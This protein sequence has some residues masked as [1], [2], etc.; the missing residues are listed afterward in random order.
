MCHL[1]TNLVIY[2]PEV[3][4]TSTSIDT[5]ASTAFANS[6]EGSDAAASTATTYSISVGDV[7]SG[8]LSS[9]ADEDWISAELVAGENYVIWV[10]GTGDSNNA[11]LDTTLTI[12]DSSGGFLQTNDD[13]TSGQNRFSLIEFTAT[14]TGTYYFDVDDWDGDA[15]NY[16]LRLSSDVFT[17]DEIAAYMT[18]FG[19]GAGPRYVMDAQTGGSISYNVDGLTTD[20]ARLARWALESWGNAMDIDF[21]RVSRSEAQ[22]VFDDNQAGAFAGPDEIS[23]SGVVSQSSVNISTGWLNAY[24]TTIDSY[25]YTTYVH[26]IGHALG[27]YHSGPYNGT[28][29]YGSDNVYLNDS[30]QATVMSYFNTSEN[31]YVDAS[32]VFY[33]TPMLADLL[34]MH[35]MYG[36]AQAYTGDT[37]WGSNTNI[38][39][40]MGTLS[41]ILFDGAAANSSFYS[42]GAVGFTIYDTGGIDMLDLGRTTG[43]L[44]LDMRAETASDVGGLIGNVLIARG[45]VIENAIGN[46]NSDNITGNAADNNIEGRMGNDTIDGGIGNDTLLGQ[47]GNDSLIGGTGADYL[48]GGNGNDSL[49]GGDGNDTVYG[50][51][52]YDTITGGSGNDLIYALSENDVIDGGT[53]NDTIWGGGGNDTVTGGTGGR[54]FNFMGTGDDTYTQDASSTIDA[55]VWLGIGNDVA[56][57]GAG[58]DLIYGMRGIDVITSNDGNDTIYSGSENDTVDGGAGDDVLWVGE[59]DDLLTAGD[60]NDL[61]YARSGNDYVTGGMGNDTMHMGE[62]R[63]TAFGGAGNDTIF[64]GNDADQI[65][66]GT[67]DDFIFGGAGNDIIDMGAGNDTFIDT[68][69]SGPLGADIITG[70]AGIDT[71]QFTS[72]PSGDTITDFEVGTDI[73][74]FTQN[75]WGSTRTSTEVVDDFATVTA[76]GVVFD[77]GGGRTITLEAV[78]DTANLADDLALF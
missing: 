59:G 22:I 6:S 40:T 1:F 64:G 57:T 47:N 56:T 58:D 38:G 27:L 78:F 33:M 3:L 62:G 52:G 49:A 16:D 39:G 37:V 60:G 48:G 75:L 46:G 41:A 34:A 70:G 36:T 26:E 73:L 42:G 77:F 65:F 5:I 67:G 7:F 76:G 69:Q 20:G 71:F 4:N 45:S 74:R 32:N 12:R 11:V 50:G 19:W 63:D 15:G 23:N 44:R 28:G 2:M 35:D 17:M 29:G 18:D 31:T 30:Y 24:G 55:F 10:N 9:A 21:V 72:Q 54:D 43:N 51:A 14:T 61:V 25:S 68:F 66:G 8:N 13:I 53:G